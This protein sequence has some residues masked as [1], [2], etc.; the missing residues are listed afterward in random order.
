MKILHILKSAPDASTKKIMEAM[1]AGNQ[2]TTV[3]LTKG[4]VSYDK[5]VA[6]VFGS[7]KIFCW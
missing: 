1:S 7:D 6:E 3:D 4:D 2:S 5:L